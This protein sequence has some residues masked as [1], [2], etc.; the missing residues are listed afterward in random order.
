MNLRFTLRQERTEDEN[1][2]EDEG[3]RL[4]PTTYYLLSDQRE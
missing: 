1:E 3:C 2:N 4:T